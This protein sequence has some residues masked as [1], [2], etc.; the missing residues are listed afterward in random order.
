MKPREE[1][2]RGAAGYKALQRVTVAIRS[3]VDLGRVLDTLAADAGRVLDLSLFSI[4]RWDL[5]GRRLLFS[6]E[7]R[8]DPEPGSVSSLMG[9]RYERG[10]EPAAREFET[11]LFEDQ[12][13]FIS[14]P[15]GPQARASFLDPLSAYDC[16]VTP[17]VSAQRLAGLLVA[18]RPPALR[19]WSEEEVEFLRAAADTAAVSIL[20]AELRSRLRTLAAA[21]AVTNSRLESAER[22]RRLA[23][24]AI[25]VTQSSMGAVGRVEA[26]ALVYREFWRQGAWQQVELRFSLNQGLA[27]WSWANRAPCIANDLHGDARAARSAVSHEDVRTAMSVPIVGPDGEV[28]GIFEMQNKAAGAPYGDEDI[29]LVAALAHHAAACL[30]TIKDTC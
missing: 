10:A 30:P 7:Y 5:T 24:A 3:H 4:A 22:L 29:F 12:R 25:S 6:S 20:Y 23:E 27:G 14:A 13:S 11:L 8:R 26:G 9:R 16:V 18:A 2:S 28:V 17:I 1:L 15:G 21:A 19:P